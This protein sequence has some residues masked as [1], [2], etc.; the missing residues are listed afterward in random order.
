[1]RPLALLA[2]AALF[3][4]ACAAQTP[5][6]ITVSEVNVTADMA[7]IGNRNAAGYWQGLESD[8][9]A[10]IGSEFVGRIDPGGR[11]VN[12]D[13]DELTLQTALTSGMTAEDARLS[14][15]VEVITSDGS[16]TYDVS[17][18]TRD[19]ITY[20][21]PGT[22][23]TTIPPSSAEFYR[24]VVRAFARGTAEVVLGTDAG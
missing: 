11:I 3:L 22:N 16:T 19:A 15:Q 21:P 10:A 8:L 7:A 20:L 2:G 5:D 6:P 9:Q 24:A 1:M 4:G 13:I 23:I 14:G 12:V 17:A 18:T